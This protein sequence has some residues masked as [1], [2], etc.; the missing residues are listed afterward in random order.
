MR[1]VLHSNY[2]TVYYHWLSQQNQILNTTVTDLILRTTYFISLKVPPDTVI[3][4]C[5]Y[6]GVMNLTSFGFGITDSVTK[7]TIL[8]DSA[9][10][11]LYPLFTCCCYFYCDLYHVS[12]LEIKLFLN[13]YISIEDKCF[14]K[15]LQYCTRKL[16]V[17]VV[18]IKILLIY[19]L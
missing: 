17:V 15:R 7:V 18:I 11:C 5:I 8:T 13:I 16:Q 4:S 14:V 9:Q 10:L 12:R 1:T 2:I 19:L 6:I 3:Q